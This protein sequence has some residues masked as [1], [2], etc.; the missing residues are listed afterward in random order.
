VG[1]DREPLAK[2]GLPD[3]IPVDEYFGFAFVGARRRSHPTIPRAGLG[4][5]GEYIVE[6]HPYGSV[7]KNHRDYST[8]PP[9]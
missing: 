3:G 9:S 4:T 1:R 2:E 5:L 8:T 7:R 6:S